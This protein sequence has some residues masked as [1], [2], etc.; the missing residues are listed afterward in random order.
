MPSHPNIIATSYENSKINIYD[1]QHHLSALDMPPSVKLQ[2]PKPV[3][4][5]KGHPTEGYGLA[6]N[7]KVPGRYNAQDILLY[8]IIL[9]YYYIILLL[10]YIIIILYYIILNYMISGK[11]NA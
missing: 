6:W 4:T 3:F 10:Y 1:L 8:Y 11:Y 5:F 9:L 2:K 7:H